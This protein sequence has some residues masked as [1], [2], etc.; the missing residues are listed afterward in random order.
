MTDRFQQI[1]L[2]PAS[3]PSIFV[4][5]PGLAGLWMARRNWRRDLFLW[6]F[7][8]QVAFF[9]FLALTTGWRPQL[10]YILL[11]FV[12]LFPAPKSTIRT[13]SLQ[14]RSRRK[15]SRC[16]IP[17]SAVPEVLHTGFLRAS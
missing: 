16:R 9:I 4:V 6:L 10:R 15:S 5:L 7:V 11:Y 12:N 13:C 3:T 2:M 17:N 14:L 1:L 8:V